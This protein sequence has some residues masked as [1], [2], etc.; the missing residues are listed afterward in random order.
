MQS[1]RGHSDKLFQFHIFAQTLVVVI[2][3][4]PSNIVGD[5]KGKNR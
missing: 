4:V 5:F 2:C 1:K 3:G